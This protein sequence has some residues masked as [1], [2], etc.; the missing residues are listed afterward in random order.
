M[1]LPASKLTEGAG[2]KVTLPI[3]LSDSI[4][5]I[6]FI[7]SVPVVTFEETATFAEAT[8]TVTEAEPPVLHCTKYVVVAVGLTVAVR[9]VSVVGLPSQETAP[10]QPAAVSVTDLLGQITGFVGETVMKL[11]DEQFAP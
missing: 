4:V 5:F 1:A 8:S 11:C 9:P 3:F 7:V 6:A 10:L 2:V